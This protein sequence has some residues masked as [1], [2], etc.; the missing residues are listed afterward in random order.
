MTD[1]VAV[2][3]DE[4]T[5]KLAYEYRKRRGR[6]FGSPEFDWIAAENALASSRENPQE[7]LPLIS[8]QLVPN[9]GP[10]C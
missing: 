7:I 9:E 2:N 4:Q 3:L 10:Y 6:P 1:F 5:T 8:L